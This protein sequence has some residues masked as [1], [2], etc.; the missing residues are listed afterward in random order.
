MKRVKYSGRFHHQH[1]QH[2]LDYY[3]KRH[4]HKDQFYMS[5]MY[6]SAFPISL[7]L[8]MDPIPFGC[9]MIAFSVLYAVIAR[10]LVYRLAPS[11]FRLRR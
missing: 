10:I 5:Q 4:N 11:T 6:L 3:Q 7:F 8:R 1:R 9:V 2:N